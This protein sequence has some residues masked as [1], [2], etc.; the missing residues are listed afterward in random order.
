[1]SL[2]AKNS[3]VLSHLFTKNMVV[4]TVLRNLATAKKQ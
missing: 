1:M 4:I 3:S 2:T